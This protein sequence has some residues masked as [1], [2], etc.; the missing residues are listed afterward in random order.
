MPKTT[1]RGIFSETCAI[2]PATNS[3]KAKINH[4]KIEIGEY[5][6]KEKR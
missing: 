5:K 3:R 2:S 6:D 1:K 4:R